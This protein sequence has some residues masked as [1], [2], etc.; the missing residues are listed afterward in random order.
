[1]IANEISEHDIKLFQ[2]AL[3]GWGK[4]HFRPF[5]WRILS[6][7]YNILMAEIMLHRT[8]VAQVVPVYNEFIKIYPDLD[9]LAEASRDDLH[10]QLFPLGLHWRVKL[11]IEMVNRLVN[12]FEGRI[13][14]EKDVLIKLPGISDYIA[15]AIRCFGYNKNESLA[16]TNTVRIIA[17]LFGVEVRDSLRRNRG[18]RRLMSTLVDPYEPA[19]IRSA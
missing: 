4:E 14:E 2:K 13:P 8:Q 19:W 12:D 9:T 18:F 1:M 17:R 15:G 7:P 6:K 5:P 16:D 11:I 3:I 10:N